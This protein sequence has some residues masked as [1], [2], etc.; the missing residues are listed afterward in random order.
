VTPLTVDQYDDEEITAHA[1][2]VIKASELSDP[3]VDEGKRPATAG[4]LFFAM[5]AVAMRGP[6]STAADSILCCRLFL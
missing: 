1:L 6:K 3:E 4:L 2:N 5:C